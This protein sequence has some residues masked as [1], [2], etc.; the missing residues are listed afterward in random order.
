MQRPHP[1]FD[2]RESGHRFEASP[3]LNEW[4]RESFISDGGT[5]ANPD[6]AHLRE[7]SIG[8]LWTNVENVKRGRMVL[9]TCQ[10][11]TNSGDKWTAGRSTQ[12][13]EEWFGDL[14]DFLITIYAP[15]AA[16][17]DNASFMALIEHELYHAA[18]KTDEHGSPM[19]SNMTGEPLW[20]MRGHDAEQFIGVVARYG[21]EASMVEALVEA[22]NAGPT[23]ARARISVACG[24]CLR[25][26]G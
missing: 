7:A 9:G 12:Q 24:S 11:V 8:F 18:Q 6:H 13:L 15:A 17:M 21:A 26:V 5:V 25:L 14:P 19:F 3:E 4:C 10:L 20:A 22:A 1:P 16:E 23:I 2:M